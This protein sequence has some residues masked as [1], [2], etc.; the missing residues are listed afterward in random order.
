MKKK[1]NRPKYPKNTSIS[2]RDKRGHDLRPVS[3][4]SMYS[5]SKNKIVPM[6]LYCPDCNIFFSV[7]I[8]EIKFRKG[9]S[10]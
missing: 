2:F 7:R 3:Y 6:I 8:N 4:V 5:R 10:A 1:V 9:K